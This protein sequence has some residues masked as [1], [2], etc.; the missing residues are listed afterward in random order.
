[1]RYTGLHQRIAGLVTVVGVG[2]TTA[3]DRLWIAPDLLAPVVQHLHF[4]SDGV[5]VAEA[6]PHVGVL[7]GDTQRI[8]LAAATMR[9][10]IVLCTG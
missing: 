5:R 6:M 10:G 8:L 9:I 1:M 2:P 7:R 4:V 3:L